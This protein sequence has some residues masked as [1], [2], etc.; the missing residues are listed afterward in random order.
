MPVAAVAVAGLA[1][2]G[3]IELGATVAAVGSFTSSKPLLVAGTVLR[4][5]G[6]AWA[7]WHSLT[8]A[9]VAALQAQAQRQ[10]G[11][12]QHRAAAAFQYGPAYPWLDADQRR[13]EA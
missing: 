4:R 8:P 5:C 3:A 10:T 2:G 6:R 1:I 13:A 9:Q 7:R 11:S 12:G